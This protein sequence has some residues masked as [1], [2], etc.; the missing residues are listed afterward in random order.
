[1]FANLRKSGIKFVLINLLIIFSILGIIE[2]LARTYIYF[3]RG[4]STVGLPE[5]T[6]YL[7]YQPFVMYGP[8]FDTSLKH[9]KRLN[10]QKDN[11]RKY[12]ILLL[13]GST[14][15]GFPVNILRKAFSRRFVSYEFEV[16]NVGVGGY[17]ARQEL[18]VAAIWGAFDRTRYDNYNGWS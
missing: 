14:A 8:N 11:D 3:T 4:V 18:I 2:G 6:L 5:R 7:K 13:G 9:F 16:I 10:K 15:A 1:M 17:N 12:R